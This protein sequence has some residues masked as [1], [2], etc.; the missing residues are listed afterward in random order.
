MPLTIVLSCR[1]EA[2]D[3]DDFPQL[4]SNDAKWACVAVRALSA[5]SERIASL[6]VE[7]PLICFSL[8]VW[9]PMIGKLPLMQY[10]EIDSDDL[11]IIGN[12]QGGDGETLQ[13]FSDTPSLTS[14]KI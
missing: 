3:D 14:I 7:L 12:P 1:D 8:K 4:N 2:D 5:C 11:S 13:M 9:A 6:T 10:L